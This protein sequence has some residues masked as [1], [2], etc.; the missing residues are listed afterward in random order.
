[1]IN[2]PQKTFQIQTVDKIRAVYAIA[3][4]QDVEMDAKHDSYVVDCKSL[5]G[6]L[7][8]DLKKPITI[9]IYSN[10]SEQVDSIFN[11]IEKAI[12]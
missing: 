4:Q 8:L 2:T 1:M 10:N 3:I 12:A 5:I 7:S 6:L 11:Q 9:L